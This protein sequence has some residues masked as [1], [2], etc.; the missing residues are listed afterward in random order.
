MQIL[1]ESGSGAIA[2]QELKDTL[3]NIADKNDVNLDI[4]TI[5]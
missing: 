3:L 1:G 5:V 4:D 2:K